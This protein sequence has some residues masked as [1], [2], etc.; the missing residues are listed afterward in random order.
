MSHAS[1]RSAAIDLPAP[2]RILRS[3]GP[4]WPPELDALADPPD[5]LRIVG[6]LPL[7]AD[8]VAI[9]GTRYADAEALSFTRELAA[10]LAAVG[11]T[12]VSG[13][14]WGV[15]GAA[16]RGALEGG[17]RT[18]VVLPTGFDRA[19]PARHRSLFSRIARDG[20]ALVTEQDDGRRP[21]RW[22]FIARNRLIAAL[23]AVTVVVQA[24]VRS[25]ALSTAA[26][27][28][29][30]KK[31]VF[32]VPS[33]PWEPRGEGCLRLI[34]DGARVCTSARDILSLRPRGSAPA[35]PQ[36]L[37]GGRKI[38]DFDGLDEDGRR[39]LEVLS[40]RG[41]HPDELARAAGVPI[42]RV[43]RALLMLT[44]MGVARGRGDGT[45]TRDV[46]LERP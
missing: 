15:D 32:A 38:N 4:G 39:V 34:A 30:L 1:G 23:S 26:A 42:P 19:Y 25:G 16:H 20:G 11:L 10:E 12:V 9:V 40:R 13:G 46:D 17:G 41:Q 45:Y 36:V 37:R 43:Q 8:A 33:A 18:V 6:D 3:G 44:L 5:R 28:R 35:A 7:P 21:A 2:P 24:P 31:H 22:T 27:A 14:A 29:V